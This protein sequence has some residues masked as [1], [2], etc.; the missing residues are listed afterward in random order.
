MKIIIGGDLVPT[1]NNKKY[2]Q[3]SNL[4][5]LMDQRLQKKWFAADFRIFNLETPLSDIV[6]P[7]NKEGPNLIA[8]TKTLNGILKL[9]HSLV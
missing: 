2:F 3:N 6:D 9:K 7:I 5:K 1:E 4:D 8:S